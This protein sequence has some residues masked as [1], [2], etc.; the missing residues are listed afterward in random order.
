MDGLMMNHFSFERGYL[1]YMKY[2]ITEDQY[3]RLV[4]SSN[5]LWILRRYKLVRNA[6]TESLKLVEPCMYDS[7]E[8]YEAGFYHSLME[9]IHESYYLIDGF[10]YLGVFEELKDLFYVD[11]TEEYFR[12]KKNC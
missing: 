2:I 1:S 8:R 11:L 3:D 4:N 12:R 9:D 10:D 6:F 5:R 7:F